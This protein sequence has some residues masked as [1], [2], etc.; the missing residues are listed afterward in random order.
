MMLRSQETMLHFRLSTTNLPHYFTLAAV[1][2]SHFHNVNL[3]KYSFAVLLQIV[4]RFVI[5]L[6]PEFCS[7]SS[8][9]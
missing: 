8:F 7:V 4:S 3:E 2:I 6:F 5:M 9:G 1:R